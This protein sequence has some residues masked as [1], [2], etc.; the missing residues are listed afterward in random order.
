[1]E[2]T[3]YCQ[4]LHMRLEALPPLRFP[5]DPPSLPKNGVYFLYERG[6]AW[7]HGG[8]KLRIVRVGT[9]TGDGRFRDRIAEHFLPDESKMQWDAPYEPVAVRSVFRKNIGRVL[10][11][12][13]G[14]AK[15][16]EI[17]DLSHIDKTRRLRASGVEQIQKDKMLQREVTQILREEFSFRCIQVESPIRRK[18]IEARC[19]GTLAQCT[20]CR[21][22]KRWLGR[23]SPIVA[24]RD[25]GLWLVQGRG[26][27]P[28]DRT[29]SKVILGTIRL[30]LEM[31]RNP[32]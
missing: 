32:G 30:S 8:E 29:W 11:A 9:H 23:G 16:M 12:R 27:S 22:S 19:I 1:M 31:A 26:S 3:G 24:I 2:T 5:Y 18:E 28:I 20:L 14:D 7:G 6:E 21:P 4:W 10:L 13:R 15:F 17:W 25:G